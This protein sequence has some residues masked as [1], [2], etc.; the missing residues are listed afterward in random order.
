M[1]FISPL[2]PNYTH[3]TDETFDNFIQK[4]SQFGNGYNSRELRFYQK[5]IIRY[6]HPYFDYKHLLLNHS[7]G[8][9]KTRTAFMLLWIYY[10]TNP[11][12]KI[13]IVVYS[14][15]Q[16]MHFRDTLKKDSKSFPV[17][18]G[19][20]SL[21]IK[22]MKQFSESPPQKYDLIIFDEIHMID[23]AHHE[24]VHGL[25]AESLYKKTERKLA[26]YL[27]LSTKIILMTGTP[28]TRQ[29]YKFLEVM[30]L[31][32]P[33]EEKFKTKFTTGSD[34]HKIYFD[35][36]NKLKDDMI[37]KIIEKIR[38][39]V[40]TVKFKGPSQLVIEPEGFFD[41]TL[42]T[43]VNTMSPT[44]TPFTVN[45]VKLSKIQLNIVK[46]HPNNI[47]FSY[48]A[49]DGDKPI[50]YFSEPKNYSNMLKRFLD[51]DYFRS[52]SALYYTIFEKLN[53]FEEKS[54]NVEAALYFNESIKD[55]GNTFFVD[56]LSTWGFKHLKRVKQISVLDKLFSDLESDQSS[57]YDY[58]RVVSIHSPT[59]PKKTTGFYSP[60]DVQLIQNIYSHPKNKY[61]KYIRLIVGGK[62][63]TQGYNFVNARQVHIVLQTDAGFMSQAIARAIRNVTHHSEAESYVKVYRY[64]VGGNK[65]DN[66]TLPF[67]RRIK[68]LNMEMER[69]SQI[70]SVIDKASV[71]CSRNKAMH[72][73]TLKDYSQ[74]CN[75]TLCET[76]FSCYQRPSSYSDDSLTVLVPN[77][78]DLNGYRKFITQLFQ[79]VHSIHL[80]DL[81]RLSPCTNGETLYYTLKLMT[82]LTMIRDRYGRW[83]KLKEYNDIFY[84]SSSKSNSMTTAIEVIS[85][86][87]RLQYETSR[88]ENDLVYLLNKYEDSVIDLVLD[89]I[90]I[91]VFELYPTPLKVYVYE[92]VY[93]FVHVYRHKDTQYRH[94]LEKY[95]PYTF[96]KSDNNLPSLLDP[97]KVDAIHFLYEYFHNKSHSILINAI[98]KLRV[99]RG[100]SWETLSLSKEDSKTILNHINNASLQ[101][102]STDTLSTIPFTKYIKRVV[103]DDVEYLK[104]MPTKSTKDKGQFCKTVKKDKM[105]AFIKELT[106]YI[107]AHHLPI[108][109]EDQNVI[110]KYS[111]SNLCDYAL[112]LQ[113]QI[114]PLQ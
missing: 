109:T 56:L 1:R 52:H 62:M 48:V 80:N 64:V 78:N 15:S 92:L 77:D 67:G 40:S 69:N 90:D 14:A 18:L 35:S 75:Y 10:T 103:V 13:L 53:I 27:P 104:L 3:I 63:I 88:F 95:K 32:L 25:D 74:E 111:I 106:Q 46:Q 83:V 11:K 93:I 38:G 23:Y 107:N 71:D 57:P 8:S 91:S 79:K 99:L 50:A 44:T 87:V 113:D 65:M 59:N 36:N 21:T 19:S 112:K 102:K 4:N 37:C 94:F 98:S 45:F 51:K 110:E 30:N 43:I 34:I 81:L 86:P 58:K 60:T 47:E 28:I 42:G 22:T 49:I 5:F 7:M 73:Q 101:K 6:L 39:K 72:M 85:K 96:S 20:I 100:D 114:I 9:G 70:L 33:D 31:I 89:D 26:Y 84:L 12:S 105:L 24:G 16:D 66:S 97:Y 108:D 17:A 61:G 29:Y 2:L 55:Y 76:N 82:N 54:D 41:Y 68:Q